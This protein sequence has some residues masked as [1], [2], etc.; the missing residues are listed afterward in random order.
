MNVTA[1][2]LWIITAAVGLAGLLLPGTSHEHLAVALAIYA[3]TIVFG[4]LEVRLIY[5]RPT[6]SMTQHAIITASTMPVMAVGLWATGG[7]ESYMLPL[8]VFPML[9]VAYFFPIRFAWPQVILLTLAYATPLLYDS[10]AV[11]EGYPARVLTF[12]VAMWTLLLAMQLLKG[13]LLAAEARQRTMARQ[14]PLT[15]LANR[16]AFEDRLAAA[17][18]LA[19]PGRSGR[20]AG[21]AKPGTALVLFDLDAFKAVNDLHGHPRGDEVLC[22]VADSVARIVRAEDTLARIGGDEFAICASGAGRYGARRL[23]DDVAEAVRLADVGDLDPIR[24]TVAWSVAPRDGDNADALMR[25]ADRRLIEGKRLGP[26]PPRAV[27]R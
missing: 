16:R 3:W 25:C 10:N 26:A 4:V 15:G 6:A 18:P 23:A 8:L 24:A 7:T 20:R 19:A 21:D 2:I 27:I 12:A 1:G 5:P 13:R 17:V 9:H 11:D 14:D 22:A